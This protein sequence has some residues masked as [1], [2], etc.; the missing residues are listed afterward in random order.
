ML[1]SLKSHA[2]RVSLGRTSANADERRWL[3]AAD[4]G[5]VPSRRATPLR[6]VYHIDVSGRLSLETVPSLQPQG[7]GPRVVEA[8][9]AREALPSVPLLETTT[10]ANHSRTGIRLHAYTESPSDYTK[11]SPRMTT[12][13]SHD[14]ESSS[15]TSP[16]APQGRRRRSRWW[17]WFLI[18]T[19]GFVFVTCMGCLI[20]AQWLSPREE[21]RPEDVTRRFQGLTQTNLP[22]NYE[23]VRSY[24][25]DH[26]AYRAQAVVVRRGDGRGILRLLTVTEAALPLEAAREQ[27]Q[28]LVELRPDV[29]FRRLA[30]QPN[31]QQLLPD[32][33]QGVT[34][35]V[36][37]GQDLSSTTE[38]YEIR[39][40]WNAA[41]GPVELLWQIETPVYDANEVAALLQQI[42]PAGATA[43]GPSGEAL[44]SS[45]AAPP[46]AVT[47]APGVENPASEGSGPS[48][49]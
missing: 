16:A 41:D 29:Q 21:T 17:S 45:S 6:F 25:A 33:P 9:D 11:V 47:P 12:S 1:M 13:E 34:A 22:R 27:F 32:L 39:G 4:R 48:S 35:E 14:L 23:P 20:I 7:P 49:P 37:R 36:R 42:R 28:K 40:Q 24:A 31:E 43:A 2:A 15:E 44:P 19:G 18:A 46:P 26:F 30:T 38:C 10:I 8:D 5:W 3:T